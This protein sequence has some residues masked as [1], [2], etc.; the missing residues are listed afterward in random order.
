MKRLYSILIVL[1]I[2]TAALPGNEFDYT[3]YNQYR[4][5]P[6]HYSYPQI[7]INY[8]LNHYQLQIPYNSSDS[9]YRDMKQ[10]N[11]DLGIY[12]TYYDYFESEKRNRSYYVRL[13]TADNTISENIIQDGETGY[14]YTESQISYNIRYSDRFYF[15]SRSRHWGVEASVSGYS[16]TASRINDYAQPPF[17]YYIKVNSKTQSQNH[18]FILQL[19]SGRV[20]NVTSLHRALLLTDRLRV[21]TNQQFNLTAD[22]MVRIAQA[23]DSNKKYSS[24]YYRSSKEYWKHIAGT[25]DTLGISLDDLDVY[26]TLYLAESVDLLHHPR[27]TGFRYDLNFKLQYNKY[28]TLYQTYNDLDSLTNES[29]DTTEELFLLINPSITYYRPLSF[30]STI[31]LNANISAGPSVNSQAQS[32]QLYTASISTKYLYDITDKVMASLSGSYNYTQTNSNDENFH[33][34]KHIG[35]FECVFDYFIIDLAYLDISYN[36]SYSVKNYDH[37]QLLPKTTTG[38]GTF[39]IA[40]VYGPKSPSIY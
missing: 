18:Y 21:R 14:E 2:S 35:I 26:S 31:N 34:Q 20:R 24:L 9:L 16:A 38:D 3:I 17:D 10:F 33:L 29:D 8:D 40:F 6:L 25:F 37:R 4:I 39:K 1:I 23:I 5:A 11:S 32:R 36:Y 7:R 13:S 15:G 27:Y 12:G 28:C 22:E 30:R 19:G